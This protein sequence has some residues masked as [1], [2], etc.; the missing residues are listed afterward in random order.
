MKIGG[1]I[2]AAGLSSRMK[3]F[4]PMMK[5]GERSIIKRIILTFKKAKIDPIVIV[6]GFK[7]NELESHLSDTDVICIRNENYR[8][9]EMF[10]SVKIGLRY[11]KNRCE[12]ILFTPCDIPLFSDESI[13][14]LIESNELLAKPVYNSIGGHPILIDC[15]LIYSIL[16]YSGDGGLKNAI[17]STNIPIKKIEVNDKGILLDADTKEDYENLL[18][19]YNEKIN[20]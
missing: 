16:S 1:L 9:T 2:V 19:I 10:D 6:T 18:F 5:I 12:K 17:N 7:A 14:K 3:D 4:K 11:L 13:K 8:T 20:L 15:S